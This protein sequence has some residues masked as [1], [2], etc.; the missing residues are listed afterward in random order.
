ME[1][2]ASTVRNAIDALPS[3]ALIRQSSIIVPSGN[4]MAVAQALSRLVKNGELERVEKGLYYKT[5]KTRFGALRP[6]ANALLA[7]VL[8]AKQGYVT[9]NAAYNSFGITTQVPGT[10]IIAANCYRSPR[11][12]GGLTI[13]Y[14]RSKVKSNTASPEILQ[15]LDAL[16]AI[17]RIPDATVDQ[18]LTRVIEIVDGF[19]LA[20]KSEL[21]TCA[22][23]YNPSV[24]ALV[25]AIFDLWFKGIDISALAHSLNPLSSYKIGISSHIL[26]NKTKWKI[27]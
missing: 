8:N 12:I 20:K 23:E 22:L 25:T 15:L 2:I 10:I 11:K 17:K 24:R 21:V 13:R 6:D 27:K 19:T 5:R 1:S 16:R 18:V 26:P 4:E 9:D 7:E 14:R 3:G